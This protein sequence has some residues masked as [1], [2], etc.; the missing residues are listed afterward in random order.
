MSTGD[1]DSYP[2][3]PLPKKIVVSNEL[4]DIYLNFNV[5]SQIDKMKALTKRELY[6]LLVKCIDTHSDDDP[7]VKNNYKEFS[8][9]LIAL[10]EIQDDLK[11]NNTILEDLMEETSDKYI[12]INHLVDI[13]GYILPDILEKGELRDAKIGNVLDS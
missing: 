3:N 8:N 9:E 11:A 5:S 7:V 6:L 1:F 2:T 13:N 12:D 10:G 4:I